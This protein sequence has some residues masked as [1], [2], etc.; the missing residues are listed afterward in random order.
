M[1]RSE[2]E[3]ALSI[4]EL[5]GQRVAEE[6]WGLGFRPW[7]KVSEGVANKMRSPETPIFPH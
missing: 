1:C 6:P 5:A 7:V 3:I 4:L 2:A